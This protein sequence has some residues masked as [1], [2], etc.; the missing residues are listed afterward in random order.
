MVKSSVK[1]D[2]PLLES[3]VHLASASRGP[4][5]GVALDEMVGTARG[6]YGKLDEE[7]VSRCETS[8]ERC[9]D[10]ASRLLHCDANEVALAFNTTHGINSV[11]TGIEWKRGDVVLIPDFE[12]PANVVPWL[13]QAGRGVKLRTIPAHRGEIDLEALRRAIDD[14]TRVVAISHVEFANGFKNDLASISEMAHRHD[15]LLFVDGAQSLG[16]VETDVR[17]LGVDSLAACGYKWLCSPREP[18]YST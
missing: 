3:I 4:L 11:A 17:K 16:V 12:Y 13:R 8:T 6:I 9:R 10:L 18:A 1:A 2:F 15:A 7:M 14:R 5:P